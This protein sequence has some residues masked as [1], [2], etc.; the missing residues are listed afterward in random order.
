MGR[1]PAATE[2]QSGVVWRSGARRQSLGALLEDL[3]GVWLGGRGPDAGRPHVPV[4]GLWPGARSRSEHGYQSSQV[5]HARRQVVGEAKRLW[6]GERWLGSDGSSEPLPVEAGTKRVRCFGIKRYALENGTTNNVTVDTVVDKAT[7]NTYT[8]ITS[9]PSVGGVSLGF[10]KWA[11]T[12]T[13]SGASG[14]PVDV[15]SLI[16]VDKLKDA[17]L[18]GVE[19]LGVVNIYHV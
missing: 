15:S 14:S 2:L 5:R 18:I 1:V 6:R 10:D 12:T 7:E 19:T 9:L 17:K 13:S 11:T 8:R 16:E 4:R 3:L